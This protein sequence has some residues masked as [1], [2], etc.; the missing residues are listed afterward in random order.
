MVMYILNRGNIT[1]IANTESGGTKLSMVSEAA[2][3]LALGAVVKWTVETL[4]IW[5]GTIT[6]NVI[7]N[8]L[9]AAGFFDLVPNSEFVE[10]IRLI[11]TKS[12]A[13]K[14]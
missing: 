11:T 13:A 14:T 4:C 3:E 8:G 6:S 7:Y 2:A 9:A 1:G 12:A 10:G 5:V